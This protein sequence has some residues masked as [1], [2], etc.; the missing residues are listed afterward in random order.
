MASIPEWMLEK[1]ITVSL[2]TNIKTWYFQRQQQ[3]R[4]EHIT[5]TI[6]LV[7][8]CLKFTITYVD[9]IST[10]AIGNINVKYTMC[11]VVKENHHSSVLFG[12]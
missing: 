3:I 10:S 8:G 12:M 5:P 7:F 9:T 1:N 2:V 11:M 4:E 6:A